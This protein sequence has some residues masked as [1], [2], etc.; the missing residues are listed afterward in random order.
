M[1]CLL[2]IFVCMDQIPEIDF[3]ESNQRLEG[4]EIIKR[5]TV[6]KRFESFMQQPARHNFFL[7]LFVTEGASAHYVDFKRY[8]IK[9]GDLLF[10]AKG[11]VHAF[12]FSTPMDGL[13]MLFTEAFLSKHL[14]WAGTLSEYRLFN[15]QL[16]HPVIHLS[17]RDR[18]FIEGLV[19][20]IELEYQ[21]PDSSP[22][23][24][25]IGHLL[26]TLL[27]KCESMKE[28]TMSPK[29]SKQSYADFI[30][31]H[32]LV[33]AGL[34]KTRKVS[35]YADRM[36]MSSKKLNR[37]CHE[38][39]GQTAKDYI[40][41]MTVLELKRQFA[42]GTQSVKEISH[43]MGFDEVSNMIKFFKRYTEQTPS[44]FMASLD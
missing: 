20:M 17:S 4:F 11:Q 5:S 3:K 8:D 2:H 30:K 40:N 22:S 38:A 43:H 15:Y 16:F 31:L 18:D 10:L 44:Q 29:I 12:D 13:M 34:N 25:V 36:A 37:I 33:E 27:L 28:Q 1:P 26:L 6:Q 9:E 23:A 19:R 35:Y 24:E 41:T 14:G 7:L 21:S 39:A 32:S 42:L